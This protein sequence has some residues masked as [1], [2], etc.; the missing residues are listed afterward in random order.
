MASD[1]LKF[2]IIIPTRNEEE[3]IRRTLTACAAISYS[4]KEIIVV[5]DSS[6][7]T[8]AIVSEFGNSGVRLIHRSKNEG[9]R[10]GARNIGIKEAKGEVVIILNADVI[11]SPDF[12]DKILKHYQNG[13]GSVLVESEVVNQ[14]RLLPRFIQAATP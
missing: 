7:D 3:D 1:D 6:D 4:N 8:P 12:I 9:G 11:L 10:C 13:A 5:D 2:S 14:E